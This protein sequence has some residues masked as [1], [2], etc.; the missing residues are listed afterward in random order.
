MAM[1]IYTL[2]ALDIPKWVIK[3]LEKIIRAFLWRGRKEVRGGHCPIAWDRVARPLR[4]GGLGI[5]NLETMGWALR[6]RWLWLQ[7][8]QPDKPWADFII[9]VPKKVQAMFIIS[10]VTEIGNGENTLFWSDHWIMGRSV[11]DLALSLLPHVKRKAFRTRTVWE[12]LDNDAWLQDFRRGLSVPTIW[13]FMQLWEA[14]HEV[15]L[16]P[17]DQDEHCWLPDASGKYTTRS[18]YLRFF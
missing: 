7:K 3:A 5:H 10:V 14:V 4:L 6:M 1:P 12:A 16:R 9:N 13:E 2:I 17:D 11:A 15:E 8:T 18:A